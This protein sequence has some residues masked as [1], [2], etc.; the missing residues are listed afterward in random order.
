[1]TS[2]WRSRMLVPL[3]VGLAGAAVSAVAIATP[4]VWFDEAATVSATTRSIPDLL[5]MLGNVDAVHGLYYGLMHVVFG[6][7]GFH[8]LSLRLVSAL[9]VG[10]T[11]ALVV[12]LDRQL[13]PGWYGII[14]GVVFCLLPRV[15][16]MGTAIGD[17]T[18]SMRL[19][20]LTTSSTKATRAG[21]AHGPR[22]GS[23]MLP[24]C[25]G[26]IATP[27]PSAS[28]RRRRPQDVTHSK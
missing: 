9:A 2:M 12:V 4:S 11:A 10:V 24:L 23:S 13:R 14:T 15:T 1:M 26:P 3:V 7:V 19:R 16:W 8:P 6:A 21:R 20:S 18:S 17:P 25:R 5:R 28:V 27:L 22:P